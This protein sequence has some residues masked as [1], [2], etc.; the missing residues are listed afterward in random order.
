[1]TTIDELLALARTDV[2][3]GRL[4]ACQL[5]VAKDGELV[6]F[7][8]FGDATNDT[9][10]CVFSCTKP[11]VASAVWLLLGEG[12]LA[13]D[14]KIA[15]YIPEFATNGKDVVTLEQ[16][17]LH[18][19][20]FPLAPITPLEG[21]TAEGRAKRF[22]EWRL[23][24]EPGSRFE[25]HA[26]SAHYVLIDLIQRIEGRDFR[27]VIEDRVTT[28]LGLPR[29]LGL[30]LDDQDD[31]ADLVVMEP[32]GLGS[33]A[34]IL[35]GLTSPEVV[36]AGVPGGGGVMTAASLALFYQGLLHN[37]GGIWD[38]DTLGDVTTNV[39]CV[40][41]EPMFNLAGQSH[42]GARARGRRR[43]RGDA[44]RRV[45][46]H[47]LGRHVRPRRRVHADRLGR[48]GDGHLVRLLPQRPL[49]GHDGRR[50]PWCRDGDHRSVARSRL[51]GP[52]DPPGPL[53][54]SGGEPVGLV[55]A[56]RAA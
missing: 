2:D 52:P 20:G 13:L 37:P 5:A 39:R 6:V 8:T 30:D 31:I 35:A 36:R 19:S 28:P 3:N 50:R 34:T 32:G 16:V 56:P 15:E 48:S 47:E 44:V 41:P 23:D 7:E 46:H 10:F 12:R 21:A 40:L 33:D 49:R 25:Y 29:L 43:Q 27:E 11:I 9:R 14:G 55:R 42:G 17:L 1:M 22:E 45:R 24:W 18:T 54:P 38:A 53:G 26:T 4:P 51:T